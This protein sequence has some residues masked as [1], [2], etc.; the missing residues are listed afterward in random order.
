[1]RCSSFVKEKEMDIKVSKYILKVRKFDDQI[2]KEIK[3]GLS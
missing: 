2:E 3:E 1:M